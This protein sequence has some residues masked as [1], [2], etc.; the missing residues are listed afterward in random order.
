ME[1]CI[2]LSKYEISAEYADAKKQVDLRRQE[3][4]KEKRKHRKPIVTFLSALG[5]AILGIV[6][7]F[8]EDET[9]ESLMVLIVSVSLLL[10][11]ISFMIEKFR[12]KKFLTGILGLALY[13]AVALVLL[14][15]QY[16]IK[17]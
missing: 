15:L 9:V 13:L 14:L 17:S 2:I 7:L 1:I 12:I 6:L 11:G 3:M 10:G 5:V 8:L 16:Y 4:A